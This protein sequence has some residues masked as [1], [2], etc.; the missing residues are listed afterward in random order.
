MSENYENQLDDLRPAPTSEELEANKQIEQRKAVDRI[1]RGVN[2]TF[3]KDYDFKDM[4]VKFTIKVKA[5]NALEIGR[6]QGR[7]SAYLG[8]MNNYAS[9]YML[10][11]YNMLATLRVTGIDVPKELANDEDIY[12]LDMLYEIGR[13]FKQWL[14]NFRY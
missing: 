14:E 4:G 8:G 2:D 10:I 1:V 3:I 9:E 7:M 6:I 13:D 11:V 12:N 5:P